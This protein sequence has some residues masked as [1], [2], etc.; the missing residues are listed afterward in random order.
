M[1]TT[2]AGN[3]YEKLFYVERG[4]VAITETITIPEEY[5]QLILPYA[6]VYYETDKYCDIISQHKQLGPFSFWVQEVYA[7]QAMRLCPYTPYHIWALHFMYDAS[8][9]V[10]LYKDATFPLMERECNLFSLES[11]LHKVEMSAGQKLTSCH[12]NIIPKEFNELVKSHPKLE[13]LASMQSKGVTG[14]LNEHPYHI[15][16]VCQHLLAAMLSCRHINT[17]ADVFLFRCC[18]DLFYNFAQ[19]DSQPPMEVKDILHTDK[20]N[21]V[22]AFLV[23]KDYKDFTIPELARMFGLTVV[24]LSTGFLKQFSIPLH[25]FLRMLKMMMV[26]ELLTEKATPLSTIAIT[27]GYKCWQDLDLVFKIY[28]GCELEELRRAM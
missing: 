6:D 23:D 11:D 27:A 15:N 4:D 20:L 13:R 1:L 22:F 9:K 16:L 25:H 19:Q 12:I 2:P 17:P 18:L 14:A 7:H 26:F 5:L 10:E 24:E 21:Q 3:R 8:L 28:Y